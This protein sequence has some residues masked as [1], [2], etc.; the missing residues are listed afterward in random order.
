MYSFKITFQNI[1]LLE[2]VVVVLVYH[3]DCARK[4]YIIMSD[5][6]RCSRNKFKPPI[7]EKYNLF[8]NNHGPQA[9]EDP[10]IKQKR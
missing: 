3:N 8:A 7:N 10:Y 9:T 4:K 5:R 2:K 6:I 1:Y